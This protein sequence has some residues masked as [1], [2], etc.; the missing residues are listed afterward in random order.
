MPSKP[1]AVDVVVIEPLRREEPSFSQGRVEGN[2]CV[3]LTH[4][5]AVS[6]GMRWSCGVHIEDLEIESGE[7]LDT[8][9]RRT[10]M[11]TLRS[12]NGPQNCESDMPSALLK[13]RAFIRA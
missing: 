9:E 4:N 12:S 2:S 8:R 1:P 11:A 13:R 7:D 3:G 5:E 6:I 10:N